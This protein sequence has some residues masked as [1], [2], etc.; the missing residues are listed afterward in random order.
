MAALIKAAAPSSYSASDAFASMG[1]E[2]D[3]LFD[4]QADSRDIAGKQI[5]KSKPPEEQRLQLLNDVWKFVNR[6]A[7]SSAA[8]LLSFVR[9]V[10]QWVQVV[11]RHYGEKE[12]LVLLS[13]LTGKLQGYMAGGAELDESVLEAL[14]DVLKIVVEQL[15][16]FGTAALTSDH[17]PKLIDM[18]S[19]FRKIMICEVLEKEFCWFNSAPRNSDAMLLNAMFDM[20]RSLHDSLDSLSPAAAAMR[21][22]S[23]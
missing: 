18:L 11:Q 7:T 16:S 1:H 8:D 20:C 10:V 17:L 14:E 23:A 5:I 12:L 9:C 22:S 21:A 3:Y 2:I 6:S 13:S 19:P 4:S 15:S